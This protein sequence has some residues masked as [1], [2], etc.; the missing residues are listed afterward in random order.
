[1]KGDFNN[2]SGNVVRQLSLGSRIGLR[3]LGFG[4]KRQRVGDFIRLGF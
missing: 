3:K 2:Y 4:C 1:V